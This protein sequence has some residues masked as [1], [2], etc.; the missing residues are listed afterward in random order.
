VRVFKVQYRRGKGLELL[1]GSSGEVYNLQ[2]EQTTKIQP[3]SQ[4]FVVECLGGSTDPLVRQVDF[5]FAAVDRE[6]NASLERLGQIYLEA[7]SRLR[8]VQDPLAW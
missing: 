8:L 3:H 1:R 7:Y 4:Q 2:I 5:A 6:S